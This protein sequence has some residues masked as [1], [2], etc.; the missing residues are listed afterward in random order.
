MKFDKETIILLSICMI[1]L[2][3]WPYFFQP[4]QQPRPLIKPQTTTAS[5]PQQRTESSEAITKK[6]I[7]PPAETT[8]AAIPSLPLQQVANDFIALSIDP[9][10]GALSSVTLKKYFR[11]DDRKKNI[12]LDSSLD[13]LAVSA[14]D[15]WT[16]K[17]TKTAKPAQGSFELTRDFS[18]GSDTFRIIQT[19]KILENYQTSYDIIFKNTGTQLLS[20]RDLS[21]SAGGMAPLPFVSGDAAR[22]EYHYISAYDP[23]SNKVIDTDTTLKQSEELFQTNKLS[24]P[25]GWVSAS[26]KYF[27]CILK[28][29]NLFDGGNNISRQLKTA[30]LSAL[31]APGFNPLSFFGVGPSKPDPRYYVLSIAGVY[32]GLSLTPGETKKLS[33]TYYSG[34][35]EIKY[36]E[37]FAPSSTKIMNLFFAWTWPVFNLLGRLLE[38]FS[39]MLLAWLIYFKELT[40]SY[41][42]GIILLTVIVRA[43]VWPFSQKANQSMKKMQKLQPLVAQIKEKHKGNPQL[44]NQQVMLLYKEHKANPVGGCLP[45]LMQFPV[46]LSLY[47]TIEG[48][49]VLRHQSFLWC[50]DLCQPDNIA[51]IMGIGIH[52]L[53]IVMTALMV[54]QQ[55]ITPSSADPAQ[56]KMMMFMPVVMLFLLYNLPSGLTLYWTISQA[57]SIVQLII[58]N[59]SKKEEGKAAASSK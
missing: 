51:T 53:I 14:N 8:P 58:N 29:Q 18:S 16:L 24:V 15:Q 12:T 44:M 38:W 6:P 28:A 46:F 10:S 30:P 2:L 9:N 48:A 17:E 7:A 27:A 47:C 35:K 50:S 42:I 45:A 55:K 26:N 1:V 13:A 39:Q 11:D 23:M 43:A 32:K 37:E 25:L 20:L 54:L 19:W 57:I 49:V 56:Q 5:Q 36:L 4:K 3:L 21:I 31:P 22:R 34:P 52:P 59:R 40:G 41:G 33:F